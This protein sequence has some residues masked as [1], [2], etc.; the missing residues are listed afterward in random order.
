[1]EQ[2]WKVGTKRWQNFWFVKKR[3]FSF[4]FFFLIKRIERDKKKTR[5]SHQRMKRSNYS[6]N[7]KKKKKSKNYLFIFHKTEAGT[8]HGGSLK[9]PEADT[10]RKS[11]PDEKTKK[12][13]SS[14]HRVFLGKNIFPPAHWWTRK[15]SFLLLQFFF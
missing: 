10:E 4:P 7:Y 15:T 6:P 2:Y 5:K 13:S 14:T 1:M 3:F 9:T 12:I 8:I 11:P